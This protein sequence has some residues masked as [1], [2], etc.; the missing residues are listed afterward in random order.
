M[1]DSN[2]DIF[3]L[4]PEKKPETPPTAKCPECGGIPETG[5]Q[6]LC[7][8]QDVEIV[9]P[10]PVSPTPPLVVQEDVLKHVKFLTEKFPKGY[11]IITAPE[12][13]TTC[14][15]YKWNPIQYRIFN[16]IEEYVK[17][18]CGWSAGGLN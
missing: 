14:Q 17:S 18:V 10:K 5:H 8:Q 7:S 1:S 13:G 6:R 12:Q 15:M 3:F 11:I 2:D 4:P 9:A 16:L